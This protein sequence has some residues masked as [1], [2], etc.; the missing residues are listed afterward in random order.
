MAHELHPSDN[1]LSQEETS[2]SLQP[3]EFTG[4]WDLIVNGEILTPEHGIELF[5]RALAEGRDYIS[6]QIE[7]RFQATKQLA[8]HQ[9]MFPPPMG[10]M[11]LGKLPGKVNRPFKFL[12]EEAYFRGSNPYTDPEILREEFRPF[13]HAVEQAGFA[14]S[15]WDR[16][17]DYGMREIVLMARLPGARTGGVKYD[18][19]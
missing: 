5:T 14:P 9:E 4:S 1:E 6:S 10:V 13:W 7:Q 3:L 2:E 18:P 19:E 15:V 8:N 16:P 12:T 17:D 11:L